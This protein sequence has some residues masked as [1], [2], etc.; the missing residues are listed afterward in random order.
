MNKPIMCKRLTLKREVST[1]GISP[2]SGLHCLRGFNHKEF[3]HYSF[4]RPCETINLA[5]SR[6][7][8]HPRLV[9]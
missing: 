9:C 2:S 1:I 8:H 7:H 5:F 3:N 4:P 6:C